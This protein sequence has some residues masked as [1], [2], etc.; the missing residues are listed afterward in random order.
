MPADLR[1]EFYRLRF[2]F[3]AI[4]P[5]LFPPGKAGNIIR[6]AFGRSFRAAACDP[7][8][9]DS[10][11]CARHCSYRPIFE[12]R[13]SES[14][15]AGPSGLH[16]PPRP[17]II[18]A[19]DFDGH[20]IVPGGEFWFDLHLFDVR[21][22]Q[23]DEYRRAFAR[24]AEDGVGPNQAKARLNRVEFLDLAGRPMG[25]ARVLTLGLSG[26]PA[27]AISRLQVDFAT[28]TEL[29]SD[30]ALVEVPEF[31][32]LIARLRDRISTLSSLYGSGPLP[33]DFR[34]LVERAKQVRIAMASIHDREIVRRSG[35]TGQEHS[36]G[37]FQ[38]PV[39]Y[40]GELNEFV[41]YL[42]AGRWTGVGRQTAWGKGEIRVSRAESSVAAA[43]E[44]ASPQPGASP[45]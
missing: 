25:S 14:G 35:R 7:A 39:I 32:V 6:G 2:H 28:P 11:Q 5:V 16:D 4:E 26:V 19:W 40:E 8:C 43:A 42:V 30:G 37:G 21:N 3:E 1:F 23:V 22:P 45:E 38:G 10:K 27:S 33:I 36:I 29:K 34:S 13:A 18:R 9:T 12:P 20:R 44:A 41:P 15:G 17:F 24:F 31:H